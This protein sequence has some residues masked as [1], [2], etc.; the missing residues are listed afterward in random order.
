MAKTT[1]N[2]K[3]IEKY[4]TS[5][6]DRFQTP[7]MVRVDYVRLSAADLNKNYQPN[8]D[9]IKKAYAEEASRYVTPAVRRASNILNFRQGLLG[10]R[11]RR[12]RRNRN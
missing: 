12:L 2:E 3:D 6:A 4:Y 8:E 5:N 1:V 10:H 11:L 7:E 9:D